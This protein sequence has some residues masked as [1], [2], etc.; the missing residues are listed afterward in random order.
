MGTEGYVGQGLDPAGAL[1]DLLHLFCSLR[2]LTQREAAFYF[3]PNV[4]VHWLPQHKGELP[5]A[6]I[7]RVACRG[8]V[9]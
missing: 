4:R 5:A 8:G 7:V 6:P 2:Q 3:C 1:C 9:G